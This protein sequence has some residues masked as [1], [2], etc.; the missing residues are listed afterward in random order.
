[1]T[2]GRNILIGC[3]CA[4]VIHGCGSNSIHR[5]ARDTASDAGNDGG[6]PAGNGGDGGDG[7]SGAATTGGVGG[8]GTGGAGPD[9]GA[10]TSPTAGQNGSAGAGEADMAPTVVA[11]LD[12]VPLSL[13]LDGANLYVTVGSQSNVDGKVQTVA[14]TAVGATEAA[15]GG[16]TTLASGLRG[17]ATINVSGDTVYWSGTE[18]VF[19]NCSTT[20]TVPTAGGPVVDITGGAVQCA[21]TYNRIPIANSVLYTLTN[22][23][24]SISAFPLPGTAGGAGQAIYTGTGTTLFGV[25]SDGA[26]VFFLVVIDPFAG[27]SGEVDLDQ[28]PVG[29]GAVTTLVKN[30]LGQP[31][32]DYVVH[33]A[34]TVYWTEQATGNVYSVPKTGGKPKVLATSLT[35][36]TVSPDIVVDG[37]N[38]YALLPFSLVRFPK[39]GGTPVTLASTQGGSADS[40]NAG[41]GSV[42]LAVDD[43]YVYWLYEGHGQI[44]KVPK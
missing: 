8:Q 26:S 16:I 7:D 31:Y 15:G 25:D 3:C 44:L 13:A 40:Y 33:D 9:G 19:P 4:V 34:T 17:P 18:A 32:D 35:S 12:Y 6:E 28:V 2:R 20:F 39:T 29:G 41:G 37:N 27:G 22:N 23:Y 14:K 11:T 24:G 5:V 10:D 36:G 1:M 38:I 21:I 42:A 30:V 43:T